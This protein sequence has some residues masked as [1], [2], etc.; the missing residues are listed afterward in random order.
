LLLV[1]NL[2]ALN[3]QKQ[4]LAKRI[5]ASIPNAGRDVFQNP[6]GTPFQQLMVPTNWLYPTIAIG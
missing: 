2:F 4:H 3:A 6:G 5:S 1:L